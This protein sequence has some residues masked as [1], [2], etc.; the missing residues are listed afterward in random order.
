MSAFPNLADI[1]DSD[2]DRAG[3]Q[4]ALK[5]FCDA[6]VQRIGDGT[7]TEA[8]KAA[9][10][11]A[12]D[13]ARGLQSIGAAVASNALTLTLNPTNLEFR[14]ATLTSGA[15]NQRA[16]P[17]AITL[18]ISSGSTLGTTN[19][20]AARLFVLAIDNAGTVELAVVNAI[21]GL[22]LN[23]S[24]VISTTAEGGAG[25]A[26]SGTTIYSTVAR[27]NVPYRVVGYVEVTQATA[28]TWVTAPSKVQGAGGA[29]LAL[30][31]PRRTWQTLTGSRSG[32]TNYT[33]NLD[34][35]IEVSIT[36]N[37]GGSLQ[38]SLLVDG[39]SRSTDAYSGASGIICVSATI[40]PGAQYSLTIA[41]GTINVWSE[42]R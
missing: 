40:P 9:T 27:S 41:A 14:S 34:Y 19:A 35:D 4:V 7:A 21:S 11:V 20:V 38:F 8:E 1:F 26:D 36:S 42:L 17:A 31:N 18:T 39:A 12:L 22:L 29:V 10:R 33:N 5:A 25:A 15:V 32:G 2:T 3:A 28:G 6:V 30:L 37:A 24:G 13:A 16:V 23:E